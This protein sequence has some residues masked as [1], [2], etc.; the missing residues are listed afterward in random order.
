[1]YADGGTDAVGIAAYA[2]GFAMPTAALGYADGAMPTVAVSIGLCRRPWAV[3]NVAYS[4]SVH[5]CTYIFIGLDS[6]RC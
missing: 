6:D 2:D 3:G 5:K 1:M 4:G